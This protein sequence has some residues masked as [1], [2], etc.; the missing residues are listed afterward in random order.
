MNAEEVRRIARDLGADLCGIASPDRF[1][2]APKGYQ[3]WDVM[4]T[5]RS[6]I[7][8][9]C[10]FPA[11]TLVCASPVPYT[12]V[13]NTI[14]PKMDAIALAL[15]CCLEDAGAL[16]APIPCNESEYDPATGRYRSIVSLKHAAQAAGLGTI[17]RHSLLITP[18]YGSMVWLGGVLTE[19]ELTPDP[20]LPSLCDG[21]NLCV[22]ACPIHAL[23]KQEMAQ[24]ACWDYAFGNDPKKKRWQ[25]SCHRCRDACPYNLV[26]TQCAGQVMPGKAV[27]QT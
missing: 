23:D 17:G 2:D 11:G 21:C 9:A 15:C 10:R 4:P 3:P 26:G 13:R 14:T 7:A 27:V 8:L 12:R 19:M 20:L 18:E 6:V 1:S 22:Q 24:Q 16:S 25:I 5:C